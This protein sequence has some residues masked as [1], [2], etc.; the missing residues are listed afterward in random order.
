MEHKPLREKEIEAL[1][2]IRN[3]IAHGSG[4]PSI[5]ELQELLGYSSPNAAA[6]LIMRLAERGFVR[7]RPDGKLQMLRELPEDATHARTVEVPLVGSAPCGA[8][9]LAEQNLEAMVSVSIRLARPPHRYFLLRARGDSMD[10]AG[11]RHGDL[12]L[13][14]QQATATNGDRVV[15]LIDDNATIK[16]FRSAKD[17][18][19][20]IPRSSRKIH[21]PI[22]LTTDFQVQGVV[23]AT[24]P[25]KVSVTRGRISDG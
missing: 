23:V 21:K 13:V 4:P 2:H 8:P 7:R 3:A 22:V 10:L 24:I 12:V 11:I 14:R 19:M 15:A 5:R 18:I 17:A 16:E 6:Y 25:T 20:L 9:L 1:R